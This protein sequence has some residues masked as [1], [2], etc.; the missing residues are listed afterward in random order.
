MNTFFSFLR[1]KTDFFTGADEK[2]IDDL[3]LKVIKKHS[4]IAKESKIQIEK[5]RAIRQEKERVYF[6]ID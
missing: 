6:Q 4:N 2:T 5:E 3:V 1:R